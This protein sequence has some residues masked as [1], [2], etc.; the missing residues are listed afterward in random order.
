MC[1]RLRHWG[2][3]LVGNLLYTLVGGGDKG[4][5]LLRYCLEHKLLHTATRY[6]FDERSEILGRKTQAVGIEPHSPL[7]GII[8]VDELHQLHIGFE[9]AARSIITLL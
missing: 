9:L 7:T 5:R 1:R 6:G 2:I 4:N 8:A 3:Q